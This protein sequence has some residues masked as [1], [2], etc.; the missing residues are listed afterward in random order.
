MRSPW[1]FVAAVALL[2]SGDLAAEARVAGKPLSARPSRIAPP[3]ADA[4]RKLAQSSNAF[5]FDLY[6]RLRQKPGN[7]VMSPASLTTALT[8]AWGGARG[9]TAA[10]MGKVLH[11][12]GTAGE[13]M[14]ASG[15]LARSLQDPSRPLV[16]RI[17]NQLF[18]EKTYKL[19]PAFVEKTR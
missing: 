7:L 13:M 1:T 2:L 4:L 3:S 6:Q 18:G 14:T 8:M 10:Q 19:V 12:Q 9:E 5:G 17:A 11:L 15:Q 16:F